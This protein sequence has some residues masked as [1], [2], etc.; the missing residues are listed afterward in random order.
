M[1]LNFRVCKLN[2]K[3]FPAR[4]DNISKFRDIN[5]IHVE[6]IYCGFGIK[7]E[8]NLIKFYI[9]DPMKCMNKPNA[10]P[11]FTV[12]NGVTHCFGQNK[13]TILISRKY[14][15]I[16]VLFSLCEK[17]A[18]ILHLS[19]PRCDLYNCTWFESA[20]GALRCWLVGV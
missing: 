14:I 6:G 15:P 10:S 5:L 13:S 4:C 3:E 1:K 7:H 19:W 17:E 11:T 18:S 12:H 20:C 2:N 16:L 8:V 9:T